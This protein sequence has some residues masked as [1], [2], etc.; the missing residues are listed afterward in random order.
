MVAQAAKSIASP[1]VWVTRTEPFCRLTAK[2]L[3]GMGYAPVIAPVL[4]VVPLRAPVALPVP[5]ALVF[6]SLQGIRLHRFLPALAAVPV[7]AVGDHS[8]RFARTHGYRQVISAAGDVHDLRRTIR[9]IMPPGASIL[10]LGTARPAGDLAGMLRED[11]FAARLLPIYDVVEAGEPDLQWMA[12]ELPAIEHILIH[13][14]RAGRHVADW[15][16]RQAPDWCGQAHCISGKA[17]APFA[18][19]THAKVRVAA[20]PDEASLLDLLMT[21]ARR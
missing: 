7:F 3:S 13:S 19:L 11:G 20:R 10:H 14:P 1:A 6:T 2:R 8:A 17:A 15:L 18:G 9:D 12:G 5:D 16:S 21:E 4:K